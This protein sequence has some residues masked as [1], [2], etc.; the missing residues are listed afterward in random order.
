MQP[1]WTS[2]SPWKTEKSPLMCSVSTT[3]PTYPLPA[4]I[5]QPFFF[6]GFAQ[7]IG[8]RLRMICSQ[9]DDLDRRLEEY[10]RYLT[11][12][13]WKY[14]TNKERLVEGAKKNRQTLLQQPRKKKEKKIA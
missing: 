2:P 11:I 8:T 12:S 7:G 6:K 4:A 13:G 1:T 5:C 3:T 10:A 9:E 14:K